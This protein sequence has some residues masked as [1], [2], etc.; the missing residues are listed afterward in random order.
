[1]FQKTL[2]KDELKNSKNKYKNA[3]TSMKKNNRQQL[4]TIKGKNNRNNSL[5]PPGIDKKYHK[6]STQIDF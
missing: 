1:M 2:T 4:E 5:C 3:Q 6:N